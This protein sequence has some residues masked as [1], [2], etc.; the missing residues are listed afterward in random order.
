MPIMEKRIYIKK[1]ISK[2]LNFLSLVIFFTFLLLILLFDTNFSHLSIKLLD[3]NIYIKEIFIFI[4]CIF[5][6]VTS[7]DSAQVNNW[8]GLG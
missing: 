3:F 8:S 6:Y 2:K 1:N 5:A 7:Y 4:F